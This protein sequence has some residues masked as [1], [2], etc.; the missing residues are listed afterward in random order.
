[1]ATFKP[2][3]MHAVKGCGTALEEGL[4]GRLFC[5]D[6][7]NSWAKSDVENCINRGV[8]GGLNTTTC[9]LSFVKAPPA[10]AP[11]APPQW[12]ATCT[13]NKCAYQV[14]GVGHPPVFCG[15]C[16]APFSVVT[17]PGT[18]APAPPPL[19]PLYGV[20][21]NALGPVVSGG[22]IT[23]TDS[24]AF[25]SPDDDDET[26]DPGVRA[27]KTY[28]RCRSCDVELCP[29]LDAV[30]SKADAYDANRC[31]KCRGRRDDEANDNHLDDI[32]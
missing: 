18:Q 26:T 8:L 6:C 30:W 23:I 24:S 25:W 2:E 17:S 20:P 3:V 32:I 5:P 1:M 4:W 13:N 22:T 19:A 12:A 29:E 9:S 7:F 16:N 15:H 11:T 21:L 27:P 10:P 31:V 28:P 14:S